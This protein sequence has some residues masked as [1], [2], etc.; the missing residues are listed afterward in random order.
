MTVLKL[1]CL[2]LVVA[3]A[4]VLQAASPVIAAD[5]SKQEVDRAIQRAV[6]FLANQQT[7]DGNWSGN[8]HVVGVTSLAL[9]CCSTRTYRPI[10]PS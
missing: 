3:W 9:W 6:Q 10:I 5:V 1:W 8:S 2:P 7:L 4:A